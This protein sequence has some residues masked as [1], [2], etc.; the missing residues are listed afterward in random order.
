MSNIVRIGL[1]GLGNIGSHH[2]SYIDTLTRCKLAAVSD[3]NEQRL[4]DYPKIAKFT[5]PEKMMLSGEID[6]V[7]I[8]TPHY[9][10]TPIAISA[11]KNG[12]HVLTE[13][14]LGVHK[15]DCDRMLAAHAGTGLVF[16]V[17]F[18]LR[19]HPLYT[20]V[21]QLIANGDLGDIIRVNWTVTDWFR[22]EEYY[23][24]GDWRATW[25]GE[26]G[27]V[28]LNQCPHQLD[29][30]QWYFG[31]PRRIRGFCGFGT[32]HNIEVEDQVTAYM[33]YDNGS[34]A[35]F[36]TSTGEA[37]GTNRLEIAAERGRLV[38]ENNCISFSRNEITAREA[39]ETGGAFD[40]PPVWEIKI[41][42]A[43]PAG[44][45][46]PETIQNF[47]DA[48]LDGTPVAAPASEAANSVELANAMVYSTLTNSVIDIPMDAAGYESTLNV[49][50]ANSSH[51][52]KAKPPT[53]KV[54][55]TKSF[56]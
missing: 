37:P 28:L 27:G 1:I 4:A 10:H 34:T 26:G 38:V 25:K 48:I 8:A 40:A 14:P 35:V 39:L 9:A 33:E 54:D 16:G 19:A 22:S 2:A 56:K 12:L 51:Q 53:R 23:A 29:L 11:L 43:A 17:M 49:L 41:P 24:S 55:V 52:K 21:K 18:Q 44:S 5:D 20:K 50:I 13:K 32:R 30:F 45:L 15:A 36:I 31:M 7:I 47:V 6:A 46:H 3:S 42:T